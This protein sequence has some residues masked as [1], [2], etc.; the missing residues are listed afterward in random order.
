[1]NADKKNTINQSQKPDYYGFVGISG[2]VTLDERIDLT[3]FRYPR[4]NLLR[5]AEILRSNSVTTISGGSTRDKTK[6]LES[7]KEKSIFLETQ[8]SSYLID[9]A[10]SN[11]T[12]PLIPTKP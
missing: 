12:D 5:F 9:Y 3:R 4:I 11:V 8:R 1:M 2:S 7:P 10:S 6:L